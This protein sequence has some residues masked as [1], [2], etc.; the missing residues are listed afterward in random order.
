MF[1]GDAV[2]FLNKSL[3]PEAI[4]MNPFSSI[5]KLM[6]LSELEIFVLEDAIKKA[7]L[8]RLDLIDYDNLRVISKRELAMLINNADASFRF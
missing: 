3:N 4:N 2:Y 1:R 7:G 5:F 8:E 6:E